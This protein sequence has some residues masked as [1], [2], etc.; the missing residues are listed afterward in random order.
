MTVFP[1]ITICGSMRY[2]PQML[3]V[4]GYLTRNGWIVLMPH[5]HYNNGIKD[6]DDEFAEMLDNMHRSKIA[7]S[8]RIFICTGL[9]GYTGEST[10][11][12]I[13]YA[14]EH[15]IAISYDNYGDFMPPVIQYTEESLTATR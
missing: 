13:D 4:A 3:Y 10:A 14:A 11:R 1:V 2:Y 7:M 9:T 6:R 15:G 12:E 5:V 8:E